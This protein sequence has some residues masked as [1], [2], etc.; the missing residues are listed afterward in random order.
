LAGG[1]LW[2]EEIARGTGTVNQ[3]DGSRFQVDLEAR[4]CS[5][6]RF[7]DTDIPCG[8][9]ISVIYTCGRAPA[10]YFPAYIK[11]ESWVATYQG[12]N[13][14]RFDMDEVKRVHR[15]GRM[16]GADSDSDSDDSGST[17]G[18][19]C[20]IDTRTQRTASKKTSSEGQRQAIP[21]AG[22]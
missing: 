17:K 9:A 12:N 6:K 19:Q 10:A 5:C 13:I 1:F 20:T 14:P 15:E 8:H 7:Q 2:I 22:P 18:L 4:T 11:T 3:R 16:L 21:K